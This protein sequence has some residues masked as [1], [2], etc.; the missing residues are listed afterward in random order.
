[1]IRREYR[2]A[3]DQV[4]GQDDR[5]LASFREGAYTLEELCRLYCT[6]VYT[7]VG[8]YVETAR[9][10]QIDRRTVKKYVHETE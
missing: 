1:M 5:Q 7:K 10:L 3:G 4:G 6:H 8:S 2:P 9:R